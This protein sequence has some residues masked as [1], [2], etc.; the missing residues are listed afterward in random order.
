LFFVC[1]LSRLAIDELAQE[2]AVAVVAG[3]LLDHVTKDPSNAGRL[4][5]GRWA[6]HYASEPFGSEHYFERGSRALH[7]L[8]PQRPEILGGVP[9]GVPLPVGIPVQ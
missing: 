3:V 1:S 6:L 9:H 8:L 4:N 7:V 2:V 5:V